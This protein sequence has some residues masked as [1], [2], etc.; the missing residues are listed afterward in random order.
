MAAA[1]DTGDVAA[2]E[3]LLQAA[4][5]LSSLVKAVADHSGQGRENIRIVKTGGMVGRSTFFDE[6]L[7]A[8][9]RRS[10]PQAQ[11]GRIEMSLAEAAARAAQK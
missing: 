4:G 2:R 10:L 9:V 1:A 8:A 11:I 5:E 3:I 7:D 6:R